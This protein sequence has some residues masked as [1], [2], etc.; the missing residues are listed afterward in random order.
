MKKLS[1]AQERA[2]IVIRQNG[3]TI[4]ANGVLASRYRVTFATLNG[5]ERLGLLSSTL[6]AGEWQYDVKE[7]V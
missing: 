2:M 6:V 7:S 4:V 3:G 1:P 5:L